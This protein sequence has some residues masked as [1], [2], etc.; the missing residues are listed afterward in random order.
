LAPRHRRRRPSV[1]TQCS[2]TTAPETPRARSRGRNRGSRATGARARKTRTRWRTALAPK[3]DRFGA[4]AS[5]R[6]GLAITFVAR[7]AHA[8]GRSSGEPR[9]R[10]PGPEAADTAAHG[11]DNSRAGG[12]W[13]RGYTCR[14]P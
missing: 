14:D 13:R 6:A 2:A 4:Q 11:G 10:L 8:G 1:A 5:I 9:P 7:R 12:Q 3:A